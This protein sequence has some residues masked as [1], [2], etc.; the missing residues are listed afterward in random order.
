MTR[1]LAAIVA[2]AIGAPTL[3]RAE[4]TPNLSGTWTFDASTSDTPLVARGGGGGRGGG[5]CHDQCPSRR[6]NGAAGVHQDHRE[7][8]RRTSG[9]ATFANLRTNIVRADSRADHRSGSDWRRC[10]CAR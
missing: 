7:V 9:N 2:L 3:V 10:L 6:A 1:V 4:A 5:G 8:I